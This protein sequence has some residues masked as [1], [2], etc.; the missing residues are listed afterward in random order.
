MKQISASLL[1]C[2]MFFCSKR[3]SYFTS[4]PTW[5]RALVCCRLLGICHDLLCNKYRRLKQSD[6]CTL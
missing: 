2:Y 3:A 1:D 5:T 6:D 4:L